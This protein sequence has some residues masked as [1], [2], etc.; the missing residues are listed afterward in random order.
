MEGKYLTKSQ[1][2]NLAQQIRKTHFTLGGGAN[3]YNTT[4]SKFLKAPVSPQAGQSD[5]NVG[6]DLRKTHLVMGTDFKPRCSEFVYSYS[7]KN[8]K[9]TQVEFAK[10]DL[11][12][13]NIVLGTTGIQYNTTTSKTYKPATVNIQHKDSALKIER[14]LRKHHFDLGTDPTTKSSTFGHDYSEKPGEKAISNPSLK[15]DLCDSHFVLGR[16]PKM[17][18]TTFQREYPTYQVQDN[19]MSKDKI[20]GLRKEHFSLG[21]DSANFSSTHKQFFTEKAD[22]RQDL[23]DEKKK[24]LR[25]SHF[26]LGKAQPTYSLTSNF[27]K[28]HSASAT[29]LNTNPTG[30]KIR[31]SHFTLGEEPL[32]YRTSYAANHVPPSQQALTQRADSQRHLSSSVK[33]GDAKIPVSN[34]QASFKPIPINEIQKPDPKLIKELRSNHFTLGDGGNYFKTT[35]SELGRGSGEPGKIDKNIVKDLRASHFKYG[36]DLAHFLSSNQNDYKKPQGVENKYDNSLSKNLRKT[37]FNIGSER[38]L[39]KTEQQDEYNW[40]Q[41]VPD[42]EFRSAQF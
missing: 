10:K 21:T 36:D 15:K 5:D 30:I 40:V 3:F 17:M 8:A 9:N 33:F 12:K 42:T 7:P 11:S 38:G 20:N 18:V 25:S 14:N 34:S 6:K 32:T 24:D 39:W 35:A 27:S 29:C 1:R 23:N 13:H 37:H 41:P 28:P 16:A 31:D 26:V 4:S 2:V 22:G 19:H